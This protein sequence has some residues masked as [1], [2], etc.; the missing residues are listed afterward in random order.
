MGW[1][2][3]SATQQNQVVIFKTVRGEL[4]KPDGF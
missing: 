2:G 3:V 1:I 4:V